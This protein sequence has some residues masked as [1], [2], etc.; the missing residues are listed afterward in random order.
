MKLEGEVRLAQQCKADL[1]SYRQRYA[2]SQEE[3]RQ[4]RAELIS[5]K[6]NLARMLGALQS[7]AIQV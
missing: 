5:H 1:N 4:L 2:S 3:A 6:N 7:A